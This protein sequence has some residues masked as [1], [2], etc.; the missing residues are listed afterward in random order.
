MR[1]YKKRLTISIL[2]ILMASGCWSV[3]LAI[4]IPQPASAIIAVPGGVIIG[5]A[6]MLWLSNWYIKRW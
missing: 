4:I 6:L 1:V 2:A 5:G 3:L